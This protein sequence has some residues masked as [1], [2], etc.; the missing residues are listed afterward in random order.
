MADRWLSVVELAERANIPE[1]TT[2]RYLT[3][4]DMF[5]VSD[6]KVRGQKYHPDSIAILARIKSLY[7][8]G[9]KSEDIMSVLASEFPMAHEVEEEV[10]KPPSAPPYATKEDI[11]IIKEM[12]ARMMAEI[13]AQREEIKR[14]ESGFNQDELIRQVTELEERL[15]Q[16]DREIEERDRE[17]EELK[18]KPWWKKIF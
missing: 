3:R 11:D 13:M 15:K 12:I 4:F 18:K 5:F 14:L 17:I 9:S 8:S 7:D 1:S 16:K 2:R 6:G 10:E